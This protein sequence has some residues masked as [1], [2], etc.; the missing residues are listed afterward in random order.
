M[1]ETQPTTGPTA[2]T[3][4]KLARLTRANTLALAEAVTRGYLPDTVDV[5]TTV[6]T[7][8][9]T[10]GEALALLDIARQALARDH[11]T[12]GHP[13]ASIPAVRRRIIA[14]DG[15]EYADYHRAAA[16]LKHH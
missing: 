3:T 11:G 5:G 16:R 9:G 14:T 2:E 6:A 1:T 8:P 7:F 4:T 12:R 13:V 15:F 10:P